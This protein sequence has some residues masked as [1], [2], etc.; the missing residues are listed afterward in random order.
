MKIDDDGRRST[1]GCFDVFG[2]F[3]FN[4]FVHIAVQGARRHSPEDFG[5]KFILPTVVCADADDVEGEFADEVIATV[6]NTGERDDALMR[7][8]FLFFDDF[9]RD[10]VRAFSDDIAS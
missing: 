4:N 5:F 1:D 9:L 7:E 6:E 3:M 10:A 2:D 8:I